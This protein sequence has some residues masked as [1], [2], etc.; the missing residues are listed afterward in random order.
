MP[1]WSFTAPWPLRLHPRVEVAAQVSSISGRGSELGE[2]ASSGAAE[3]LGRARRR[4]RLD[5]DRSGL[6]RRVLALLDRAGAAGANVFGAACTTWA[7]PADVVGVPTLRGRPARLGHASSCPGRV[8]D[9][10]VD[11]FTVMVTSTLPCAVASG[12]PPGL[13]TA[14]LREPGTARRRTGRASD[15][16]RP[17]AGEG[18]ISSQLG[19]FVVIGVLSTVAYG[20]LYLFFRQANLL[21]T[22]SRFAAMRWRIFRP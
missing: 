8:G 16:R 13:S 5:E 1:G 11:S 18:R 17:G 6:R 14:L 19:M 4:A 20:V 7:A 22:V 10:D 3:V 21:V 2:G 15:V 12:N 9:H